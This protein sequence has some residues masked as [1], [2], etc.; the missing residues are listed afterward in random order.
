[1]SL[2]GRPAGV[3]G[4]GVEEGGYTPLYGQ[5][6]LERGTFLLDSGQNREGIS[7]VEVRKRVVKI[8]FVRSPSNDG[9]LFLSGTRPNGEAR[10]IRGCGKEKFL[11]NKSIKGLD[12]WAEPPS[13]INLCLVPPPPPPPG[14]LTLQVRKI[15]FG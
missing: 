3:G 9:L 15:R 12:L 6:W 5:Y 1:M 13:I 8:I 14:V 7:L 10:C 4:R 11:V 2:T